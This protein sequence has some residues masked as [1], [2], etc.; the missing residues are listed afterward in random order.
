MSKPT[1]HQTP[2]RFGTKDSAAAGQ[3]SR[4][5]QRRFEQKLRDQATCPGCGRTGCLTAL[6]EKT[7]CGACGWLG[8]VER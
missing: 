5:N 7:S 3:V 4:R 2:N 1:M 6:G 8:E